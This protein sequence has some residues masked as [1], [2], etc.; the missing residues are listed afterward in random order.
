VCEFLERFGDVLK[1]RDEVPEWRQ[2][3][4][5]LTHTQHPNALPSLR[6]LHMPLLKA[7]VSH[8][9][10]AAKARGVEVKPEPRTRESLSVLLRTGGSGR[11][12][13]G[14]SI[15]S[16]LDRRYKSIAETRVVI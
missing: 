1:S 16:R 2:L 13:V 11:S 9:T 7:L 12:F 8:W 5:W 4:S 14:F 10:K 6:A 15:F 3:A